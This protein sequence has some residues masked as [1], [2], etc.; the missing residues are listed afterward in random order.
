VADAKI[1]AL[2]AITGA[3]IARGDLIPMVDISDTTMAASGTTKNTTWGDLLTFVESYNS[4]ENA[5]T[6]TPGAGFA[7]DTYLAGSSILIPTLGVLKAT[8]IYRCQ[9]DVTKTAAGVATPIINLRFGTAGTTADT[10]RGTHT[11]PAQTAAADGGVFSLVAVFRTVGSGTSAVLASR[12]ILNHNLAATGLSTSNGPL[13]TALS[14]GFDSTPAGSIIG[15]SLN[16]GTSAAFTITVVEAELLN[17][18]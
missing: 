8:S 11:F 12:C 5:S 9:F 17:L 7:A 18:A 4:I 6:S 2:T 1:S 14:G 3:N 10:S 13:T 16:G 15:V